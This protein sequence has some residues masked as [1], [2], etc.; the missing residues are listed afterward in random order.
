MF[1]IV[2]SDEIVIN[3]VDNLE[4]NHGNVNFHFHTTTLP[5]QIVLKLYIVIEI[6]VGNYDS[7]DGLANGADGIMKEYTKTKEIDV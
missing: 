1:S 3:A 2:P 7:Q 5:S 6:Y 4:Q